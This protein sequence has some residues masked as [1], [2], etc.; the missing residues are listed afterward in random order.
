MDVTGVEKAI[1]DVREILRL[2][3]ADLVVNSTGEGYAEMTLVLDG[4]E[5]LECIMERSIIE[6]IV[7]SH[8]ND[9][10]PEISNVTVHDP[11]EGG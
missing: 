11:R 7:L 4:V 5:C 9:A 2:D 3:G 6:N 1:A 8:V 10:F